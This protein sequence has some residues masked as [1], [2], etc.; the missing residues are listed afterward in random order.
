MDFMMR[1]ADT[2]RAARG[3]APRNASITALGF[4][5]ANV[6][7]ASKLNR[8]A[9]TPGGIPK[10]RRVREVSSVGST[11]HGTTR[12]GRSGYHWNESRTNREAVQLSPTRCV[13][14]WKRSGTAGSS[15]NH[16]PITYRGGFARR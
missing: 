12:T 10:S 9:T 5:L 4:F 8:Q 14:D 2:P 16:E 15:Q 1:I 6:E 7:F 3:T 11:T 13:W